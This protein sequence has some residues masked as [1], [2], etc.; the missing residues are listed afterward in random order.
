MSRLILITV[1]KDKDIFNKVKDIYKGVG[2]LINVKII[3]MSLRLRRIGRQ[4]KAVYI[5]VDG[6]G[7]ATGRGEQIEAEK[8][9]RRDCIIKT[10]GPVLL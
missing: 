1:S 2:C 5:L 10:T 6:Q 4:N 7:K 3:P 9:Q 8:M